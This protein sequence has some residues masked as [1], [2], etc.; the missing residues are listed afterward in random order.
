VHKSDSINRCV[1]I[2]LQVQLG[3]H[4]PS[5]LLVAAEARERA[6]FLPAF[7]MQA[8]ISFHSGGLRLG[9]RQV[10]RRSAPLLSPELE[11]RL[12]ALVQ[13]P[14]DKSNEQHEGRTGQAMVQR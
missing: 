14:S 13:M 8:A 7:L 4:L 12:A 6:A 2:W 1:F 5:S 9:R 3:F 10:V 11:A